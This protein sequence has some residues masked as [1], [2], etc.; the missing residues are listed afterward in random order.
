MYRDVYIDIFIPILV[1]R[2]VY[3]DLTSSFR[4]FFINLSLVGVA[5][6]ASLLPPAGKSTFDQKYILVPD[7]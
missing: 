3:I 2:Y 7:T 1:C 6:S 5:I 4:Y